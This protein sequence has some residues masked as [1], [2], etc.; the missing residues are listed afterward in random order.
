MQRLIYCPSNEK[1]DEASSLGKKLSL[2]IVVGE[3][4]SISFINFDRD[5]VSVLIV[6][7]KNQIRF[8]ENVNHG[9]HQS[10]RYTN[11]FV[12]FDDTTMLKDGDLEIAPTIHEKHYCQFIY[13]CNSVGSRS[14]SVFVNGVFLEERNYVVS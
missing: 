3:S 5:S 8:I 6:P 4:E 7:E 1:L 14:F 9:L 12:D 13:P 11:E 10:V 2:P